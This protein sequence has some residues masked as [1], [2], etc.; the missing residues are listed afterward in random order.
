MGPS[1]KCILEFHPTFRWL[2]SS[3]ERRRHVQAT[4]TQPTRRHADMPLG[5]LFG[6]EHLREALIR[7]HRSPDVAPDS[8][9]ALQASI[10]SRPER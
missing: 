7:R 9:P 10:H 4:P 1:D 2:P 8:R 5:G 6:L 3:A